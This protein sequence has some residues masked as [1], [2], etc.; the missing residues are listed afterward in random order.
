MKRKL[1]FLLCLSMVFIS[2]SKNDEP[3]NDEPMIKN[4]FKVTK[5]D[6][7]IDIHN[8]SYIIKNR[9]GYISIHGAP[10]YGDACCNILIDIPKIEEGKLYTD[11][12]SIN[13]FGYRFYDQ[14]NGTHFLYYNTTK[15]TLIFTSFKNPGR[16]TGT[17]IGY[18]TTGVAKVEFDI[19]ADYK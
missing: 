5:P 7:S 14:V 9:D 10:N 17:Y 16:I 18:T 8:Y 4:T 11:I 3:N 12:N 13:Q 15:E 19:Y 1:L 2:C 6:G